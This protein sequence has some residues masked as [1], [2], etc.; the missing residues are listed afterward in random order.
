MHHLAY[1]FHEDNCIPDDVYPQLIHNNTPNCYCKISGFTTIT[2]AKYTRT[3][4]L[5][6]IK[7]LYM[8]LH[9]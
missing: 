2:V 3:V 9:V 5:V 1:R 6:F 8:C 7:R 4:L